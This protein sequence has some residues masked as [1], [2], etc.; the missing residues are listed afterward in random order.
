MDEEL[1]IDREALLQTFLAEAEETFAHME[2]GLVALESRPG[3]DEL[4]HGLFRD[5]HTV[6]G[7]AGLV[8]FDAVRDLAHDLESVLE[9][10]RKR[11]L[12]VTDGLVTLLLHSVDVLR[13]AVSDA[14]AG[15][16]GVSDRVTA[17]RVRLGAAAASADPAGA[18]PSG[19]PRRRPPRRAAR[20]PA[21]PRRPS[22]PRAAVDRSAWTWRSST[23]CSTSPGR[24]RS[25]GAASARCW[26]AES[27]R[28]RTSSRP[29]ARRTGSTST[30]RSSS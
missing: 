13:G 10:L 19:A 26:S 20:S 4:L 29:T 18:S 9:R 17:F 5:A 16:T 23:G 1:G 14:A 27:P 24:S 21:R 8:A 28:T 11:T 25:P 15:S 12:P 2:Q 6:K 3:D 30:C 22:N 7:A